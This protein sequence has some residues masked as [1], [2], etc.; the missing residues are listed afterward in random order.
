VVPHYLLIVATNVWFAWSFARYS[1]NAA[2]IAGVDLYP[3]ATLPAMLAL[4][5][6]GITGGNVV[7]AQ[8]PTS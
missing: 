7:T 8:P 5:P 2:A 4:L 6:M 3:N 1:T